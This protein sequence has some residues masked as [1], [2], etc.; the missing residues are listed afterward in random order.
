MFVCLLF[1]VCGAEEDCTKEEEAQSNLLN[2]DP[3]RCNR[4][5][6]VMRTTSPDYTE[7]NHFV[8]VCRN[9]PTHIHTLLSTMKVG[10]EMNW[11]EINVF[12]WNLLELLG[13]FSNLLLY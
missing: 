13:N 12:S 1:V 11:E 10:G 3:G 4:G 5:N 2:H 7:W 6:Q 8:Y 9:V